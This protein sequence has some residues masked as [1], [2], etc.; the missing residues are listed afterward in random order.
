MNDLND[1][2]AKVL[3]Y[4]V[5]MSSLVIV[6]GLGLMVMAPPP[7]VSASLQEMLASK[8][9]TPTLDAVSLLGGIESGNPSSVLEL[10]TL[11]LLATPLARVIASVFLFLRERDRLYAGVTL[12]V[13][14][15]LL[16][17]IFVV[18]PTVA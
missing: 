16:V 1:A 17:A 9:G 11:I 3:R 13:L 14:A 2:I 15:M 6:A 4:G 18:G 8:F 5:V 12:L 7:G 10:G